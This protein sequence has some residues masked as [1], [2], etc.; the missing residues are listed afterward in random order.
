MG[1][2]KSSKKRISPQKQAIK[3]GRY[4]MMLTAADYIYT[5]YNDY[6]R[7]LDGEGRGAYITGERSV[8]TESFFNILFSHMTIGEELKGMLGKLMYY[9]TEM[10]QSQNPKPLYSKAAELV[11]QIAKQMN[12]AQYFDFSRMV[13]TS[14]AYGFFLTPIF[15]VLDNEYWPDCFV[16]GDKDGKAITT[17]P[18]I[19]INDVPLY[20]P[21][22]FSASVDNITPNTPPFRVYEDAIKSYLELKSISLYKFAVS[23]QEKKLALCALSRYYVNLVCLNKF[24]FGNIPSATA[25]DLLAFA[26]ASWA[27]EKDHEDLAHLMRN[28][29]RLIDNDIF[30]RRKYIY[31]N[32]IFP[33]LYIAFGEVYDDNEELI[34]YAHL[35]QDVRVFEKEVDTV[36]GGYLV[37]YMEYTC[38]PI[39]AKRTIPILVDN[40]AATSGSFSVSDNY[41]LLI[42]LGLYGL[43]DELPKELT[44]IDG[45]FMDVFDTIKKYTSE[46][47]NVNVERNHASGYHQTKEVK[48]EAFVRRLPA[49]QKASEQAK[50]LA[51]KY[52]VNLGAEY[53]IVSP[54]IR[55]KGSSIES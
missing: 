17:Q 43:I 35:F 6:K 1:N 22:F 18:N 10:A 49:G 47:I 40:L 28:L 33:E 30:T 52:R 48:V 44:Q 46:T 39:K 14:S 25:N 12:E 7:I 16:W 26:L 19:K 13:Y 42:L 9:F 29:F 5:S 2:K 24:S 37:I 50:E 8:D 38:F 51:R 11:K 23:L 34:E 4:L 27:Y 3:Y 41:A 54:Y 53:T 20:I 15:A 32:T 31:R 45:P 36:S 55:N 21:S